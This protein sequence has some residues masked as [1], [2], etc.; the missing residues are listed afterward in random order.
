MEFATTPEP[1]H[2]PTEPQPVAMPDSTARV[3]TALLR[4]FRDHDGFPPSIRALGKAAG[5]GSTS[6]VHRHLKHLQE[7]G[8]IRRHAI[9]SRGIEVVGATW[10]PPSHL[11]HLVPLTGEGAGAV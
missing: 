10:T 7:L 6:V 4:Y 9:A 2:V 3:L 1:E 5:I 11:A 8:L